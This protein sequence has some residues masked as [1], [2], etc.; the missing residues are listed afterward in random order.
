MGEEGLHLGDLFSDDP[1]G[2]KCPGSTP[3]TTPQHSD[4]EAEDVAAPLVRLELYFV[5]YQVLVI[6]QNKQYNPAEMLGAT[7]VWRKNGGFSCLLIFLFK[8]PTL[9]LMQTNKGASS[10]M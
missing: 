7:V 5:I 3:V 10:T 2:T 1:G 6:F 4:N 8:V 9:M